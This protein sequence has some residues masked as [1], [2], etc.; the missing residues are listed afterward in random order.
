MTVFNRGL[1]GRPQPTSVDHIIGDRTNPDDLATL[2]GRS[3][4]LVVDTCGCVPIEVRAS[5]EVLAPTVGFYAFVSTV[6]VFPGFPGGWIAPRAAVRS[7]RP[8]RLRRRCR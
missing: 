5:A 4:D 6:N 2:R 3:F 7:S 1:S 8:G